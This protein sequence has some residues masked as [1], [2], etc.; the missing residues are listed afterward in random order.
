M[1]G[2]IGIIVFG[3]G[4][5]AVLK[6]Q[7]FKNPRRS[8]LTAGAARSQLKRRRQRSRVATSKLLNNIIV[9]YLLVFLTP[10]LFLVINYFPS[11]KNRTY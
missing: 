8:S 2:I 4:D 10:E 3:F 7:F 11:S 6:E 1:V 9:G 5:S